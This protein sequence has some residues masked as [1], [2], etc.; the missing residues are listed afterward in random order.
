[1]SLTLLSP[2]ILNFTIASIY[3][4]VEFYAL[5]R[6]E[7]INNLSLDIN[8]LQKDCSW[9]LPSDE[10]RKKIMLQQTCGLPK[11][12]NDVKS[13]VVFV[14]NRF[15]TDSLQRCIGSSFEIDFKKSGKNV[16][17]NGLLTEAGITGVCKASNHDVVDKVVPILSA[18][19]YECCS[20]NGTANLTRVFGLYID[21]L[22]FMYCQYLDPGWSNEKL[23]GLFEKIQNSKFQ[24]RSL[25]SL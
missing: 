25:Q 4:N 3:E 11:S 16:Q 12:F 24:S 18:P 14:S 15:T 9:N 6:L 10:A 1:M 13:A 23:N 2:F 19:V 20:T 21:M 8:R 17:L 5:F 7:P 22:D